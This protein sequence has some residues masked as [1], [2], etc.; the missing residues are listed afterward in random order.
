MSTIEEIEK[1]YRE[2][3]LSDMAIVDETSALISLRKRLT[4]MRMKIKPA[5]GGV[6][7]DDLFKSVGDLIRNAIRTIDDEEKAKAESTA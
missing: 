2:L 4:G 3:E 5:E 7:L 6:E 1:V